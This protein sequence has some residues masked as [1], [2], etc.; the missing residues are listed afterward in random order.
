MK[1]EKIENWRDLIETSLHLHIHP[2]LLIYKKLSVDQK[3]YDPISSL[4]SDEIAELLKFSNC[5]DSQ[6][7]LIYK[8]EVYEKNRIRPT[9]NDKV[10]DVSLEKHLKELKDKFE[11]QNIKF[12]VKTDEKFQREFEEEMN[13]LDKKEKKVNVQ[14]NAST[15]I[16]EKKNGSLNFIPDLAQEEWECENEFCRNINSY[17][18]HYCLSNFLNNYFFISFYLFEIFNIKS[19]CRKIN[20]HIKELIIDRNN[21]N[22]TSHIINTNLGKI[23]FDNESRQKIDE[24]HFNG[25]LFADSSSLKNSFDDNIIYPFSKTDAKNTFRHFYHST[26]TKSISLNNANCYTNDL[27]KAYIQDKI[28]LTEDFD[29]SPNIRNSNN[30]MDQSINFN[31][32]LKREV[33]NVCPEKILES[34]VKNYNSNL[35]DPNIVKLHNKKEIEKGNNNGDQTVQGILKNSNGYDSYIRSGYSLCK[36]LKIKSPN[37]KVTFWESNIF[38]KNKNSNIIEMPKNNIQK[39]RDFNEFNIYKDK[40]I[41]NKNIKK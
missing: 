30:K 22:R 17:L 19:E 5:F 41:Y 6:N 2:V 18:N 10:F 26:I 21:L 40:N 32:S 23:D 11:I 20:Y 16:Q 7:D 37:K 29:S 9:E 12:K 27:K 3:A 13:K 39:K 38:D 33:K 24:N 14:E 25:H 35:L 36:E 31:S 1:Y 8:S 15:H 4:S 34:S 28:K